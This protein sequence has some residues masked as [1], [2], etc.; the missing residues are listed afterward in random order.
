MWANIIVAPLSTIFGYLLSKQITDETHDKNYVWWFFGYAIGFIILSV[1]FSQTWWLAIIATI[2]FLYGLKT[3]RAWILSVGLGL[4]VLTTSLTGT[5]LLIPA[6]LSSCAYFAY[7][8]QTNKLWF[9]AIVPT[10]IFAVSL[11]L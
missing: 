9:I 7:H 5:Y 6:I 10:L 2:F 8:K 1:I 4:L 3:L 11:L